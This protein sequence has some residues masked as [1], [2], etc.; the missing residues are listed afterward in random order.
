MDGWMPWLEYNSAPSTVRASTWRLT[1]RQANRITF[2]G[3]IVRT[4]EEERPHRDSDGCRVYERRWRDMRS[5]DLVEEDR[6]ERE[7]KRVVGNLHYA[8]GGMITAPGTAEE[9]RAA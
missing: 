6:V 4:V 3:K 1:G 5:G 9:K 7:I 8:M 2:R